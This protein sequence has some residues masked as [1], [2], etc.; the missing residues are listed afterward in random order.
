MAKQKQQKKKKG[1]SVQDLLG[2]KTFSDYGIVTGRGELLYYLVTPTNISVLS[3][4]SVEAKIRQL[5]YVLTTIPD[6]EIQCTDSSQCFDDNKAYLI[7]RTAAEANPKVRKILKKDILFLD[8]IQ[9]EMA[10]ARQFMFTAR[11]RNMKPQQVFDRSNSIQK[12]IAEQGFD[13]HRLKKDEIKRFLA[14]Y[15]E[16]SMLGEHLPD[17][18]GAQHFDINRI[19]EELSAEKE[20]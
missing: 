11:C 19:R 16:A 1:A 4:S 6:I 8:T 10:T 20:A 17:Y 3:A 12:V 7:N 9:M 5:M 14:L 15:F 2:V 18:D 13:C